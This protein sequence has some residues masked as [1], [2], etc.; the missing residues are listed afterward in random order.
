MKK[1][2]F[3]LLLALCFCVTAACGAEDVLHSIAQSISQTTAA[4]APAADPVQ[5]SDD[6]PADQA[7]QEAPVQAAEQVTAAPASGTDAVPEGDGAAAPE[8]PAEDTTDFTQLTAE[9]CVEDLA[10]YEGRLPHIV[11]DCPGAA[12]INSRIQADFIPLA[13]DPM[14]EQLYYECAVGAGRVLSVLITME[15][16][17]DVMEFTPFNL[18]LATGEELSAE[19]LLAVLNVD[20]EE[21]KNLEQPILGNEFML[22]FSPSVVDVDQELFDQQYERTTSPDNTEVERLWLAGNGQLCF[23][24]RIYGFAGAEYYEYTLGTGLYF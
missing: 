16:P 10:P 21:L 2:I 7:P 17:N 6:A 15:G 12:A 19:Q 1:T 24:G 22:Q 3:A 9:Q 18:D 23:V 8:P 13:E 14:C 11:L 5:S 4:P 20:A